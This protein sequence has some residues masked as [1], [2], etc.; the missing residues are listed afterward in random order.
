MRVQVLVFDGFDEL[1]AVAPYEVFRHAGRIGDVDVS[2]VTASGQRSVTGGNGVRFTDLPEWTPRQA[3]VLVVPGGGASRAGPGVRAELES[4][5]L[6]RQ[7]AVVHEQAPAGFVLASVCSGSLLLGGAGLL[8]GRSAT[9]HHTVWDALTG[10]GA[11]ATRA[12]VVDD[13]DI[14]TAG[15]VTSGLDLAL[16]LIDRIAGSGL[17]LAVEEEIEYE[18]RGIVWRGAAGEHSSSRDRSD[19]VTTT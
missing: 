2:L 4:G 13:G 16:H 7:L 12:R 5:K 19:A 15:G 18:R 14:V 3:G 9:T 11:M 17:A 8:V 1:D 6:P 10:F